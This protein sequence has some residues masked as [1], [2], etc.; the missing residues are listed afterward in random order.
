MV[1]LQKIS[2]LELFLNEN[3]SSQKAFIPTMGALHSGHASLIKAAKND[4]S[5]IICSVFVNPLQFN[6]PQD[7]QSYPQTLEQDIR[8]LEALGCDAVFAPSATEVYPKSYEPLNIDLGILD[9]VL[10]GHHRPGHFIGVARV[11]HRFFSIIKPHTAF[12][13]LKD[14]QQCLV[15]QKLVDQYF[16]NLK[17]QWVP[18]VRDTRGLALSSRNSRLSE[19]GIILASQL[20]Q[21]M[22][23]TRSQAFLKSPQEA[24]QCGMELLAQQA[25]DI[26][27]FTLVDS[28]TLIEPKVWE[29]NQKYI[30]LAAI[31]IEGV[32]LIDNMFI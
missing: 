23:A 32:R 15:V 24:L 17:L 12:F 5:V 18:T 19:H 20:Y 26:E 16:P 13:G 6:N 27:Y 28:Q 29:P 3:N 2:E 4:Q 7:L 14:Y 31:Y 9:Q 25:I 8:F 10:E 22:L 30:I 1:I 21:A 11:L